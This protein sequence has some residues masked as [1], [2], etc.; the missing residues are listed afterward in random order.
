MIACEL[1]C[2][3]ACTS[4]SF[5]ACCFLYPYTFYNFSK[6]ISTQEPSSSTDDVTDAMETESKLNV[7]GKLLDL[8][9]LVGSMLLPAISHGSV[10]A[11]VSAEEV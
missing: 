7:V 2:F 1:L 11:A 3:S 4:C 5:R 9:V 10:A 8:Q 6:I